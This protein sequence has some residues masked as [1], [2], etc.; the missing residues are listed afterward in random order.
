[1][2]G[3]VS[4]GAYIPIYRL[5]RDVIA[6]IWRSAGVGGEKAV[7]N[8]D[9]NSVTMAVG[10]GIDCIRSLKPDE[11]GALFFA[12]TT[13]PYREKQ[14]ATTIASALDLPSHIRTADFTDSLRSGTIALNSALDAIMAD[15]ARNAMVIASDCRLGSPHSEHELIFGDGAAAIVIGNSN[16]IATIEG[17]HSVFNEFMDVWRAEGDGTVRSWEQRFIVTKGYMDVVQDLVSA[18]FREY[19]LKPKDF[20]KVVLY[21]PDIRSHATLAKNLGFEQTQ[22]QNTLLTTVGNTGSASALMMLVAALEEGKPGDRILLINYGDGADA[23]IFR[24]TEEINKM[25]GRGRGIKGHLK[26]KVM[27]TEYHKY[28]SWRGL[29]LEEGARRPSTENPSVT[30]LWRERNRIL[31]LKGSK[32]K[33]CG[34][35]QYPPQRVCV[36]CRTKDEFE[37]Y[38]LSDKVGRVVTYAIDY[39]T[40]SKDPPAVF[41]WIDFNGGGRIHSEITDHA[42]EKPS[43]GMSVEM[44]FRRLYEVGGIHNYFWKARPIR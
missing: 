42:L 20:A 37:S 41:A 13:S 34:T 28:A 27:L 7:A 2:S 19:D 10:A 15:S 40:A 23:L 5:N 3:I 9:E 6:Q 22:V 31:A 14:S 35:V 44:T 18:V 33:R 17:T 26:S 24:I 38:K 32:C 4:Y 1:M 39:L 43:V 30:C 36:K 16:V 12:T 25:H 11:I 8:Y 29:I 21:A